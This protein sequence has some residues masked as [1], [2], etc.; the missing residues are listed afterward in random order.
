MSAEAIAG[1]LVVVVAVAAVAW[2]R[3]VG[4]SVPPVADIPSITGDVGSAALPSVFA[5]P[6]RVP[7]GFKLVIVEC[8]FLDDGTVL[9]Y[10]PAGGSYDPTA[11]LLIAIF[12]PRSPEVSDDP[13][14]IAERLA[15]AYP[16]ATITETSVRG[17]PG[18]LIDR[19]GSVT[20]TW[21]AAVLTIEQS[22][23]LSEVQ[24]RFVDPAEVLAVARGLVSVP[25]EEFEQL[26]VEAINWD[27]Q[28]TAWILEPDRLLSLLA[29]VSG[30]E[31]VALSTLRLDGLDI[32]SM[33]ASDPSRQSPTTTAK[34]PATSEPV[35][36]EPDPLVPERVPRVMVTLERGANPEAVA[37]EILAV[38]DFIQVGY[39]PAIGAA[40]SQQYMDDVLGDAEI[41]H[42]NPLMYQPLP[43]PESR[44][45]TS[46]LGTEVKLE[47][48]TASTEFTEATLQTIDDLRQRRVSV[49]GPIIHIGSIDDG[50]RLILIFANNRDYF[51]SSIFEWGAGSGGGMLGA[52]YLYGEVGSSSGEGGTNMRVRSHSKRRSLSWNSLTAPTSGNVPSP[53]TDSFPFRGPT[54]RDH[55]GPSLPLPLTA[56]PSANGKGTIDPWNRVKHFEGLGEGKR[57]D[58][59]PI[60]RRGVLT[61]AV[62]P[63]G[64][65]RQ[66]TARNQG[67]SGRLI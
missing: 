53:A 38:G 64:A 44:F 66:G 36:T 2:L 9:E 19:D 16:N 41:I 46:T 22:G 61:G 55:R 34:I 17:Q 32:V 50:T 13:D 42:Q 49:Q 23:L 11:E 59:G 6:T 30:V 29:D 62:V 1:F 27:L 33:I 48:A 4:D 8:G 45:D 31:S 26:A 43:G 40:I 18:F 58:M 47:A 56:P 5:V 24:G 60:L 63:R 52:G 3:P 54:H 57:G 51:E 20:D 65:T 15:T 12:P 14:V 37:A 10:V 25:R 7:D 35:T 67:R 21:T 39:S 28:V